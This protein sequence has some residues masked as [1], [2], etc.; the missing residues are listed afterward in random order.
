MMMTMML[1]MMTVRSSASTEMI[2]TSLKDR[3]GMLSVH[4]NAGS[5]DVDAFGCDHDVDNDSQ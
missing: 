3:Q 2:C 5:G 1:V 4:T